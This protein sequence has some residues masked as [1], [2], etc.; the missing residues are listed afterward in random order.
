MESLVLSLANSANRT[1]TENR[2]KNRNR[3][4]SF[5]SFEVWE[6]SQKGSENR[7]TGIINRTDGFFRTE[8]ITVIFGPKTGTEKRGRDNKRGIRLI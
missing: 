2:F 7:Q 6:A 5:E 3:K 8:P 4:L 1:E